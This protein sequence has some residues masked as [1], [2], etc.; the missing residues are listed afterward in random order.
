M[1]LGDSQVNDSNLIITTL[2]EKLKSSS[3]RVR[4]G[5]DQP[6][7]AD[8]SP[9]EK[10]WRQWVDDRFVRILTANIYR[11]LNESWETF[12]YIAEHGNFGLASR[13]I[14]R[15]FGT[16]TM[17]VI[18]RRMPQKYDI[19]GDLRQALYS[20]VDDWLTAVGSKDFLGGRKPNLAD[21][22]VYGV[23]EAVHGKQHY[24][25]CVIKNAFRD[26]DLS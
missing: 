11:S 1:K 17:Y 22:A 10:Q 16:A 24:S 4:K 25:Y 19:E 14:T 5:V 8:G 12:E 7:A 2:A 20:A 21:L 6:L 26:S 18:G 23:I 3:S 15:M 13:Y 9:E